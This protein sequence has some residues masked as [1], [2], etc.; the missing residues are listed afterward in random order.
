MSH[1]SD[2]VEQE[3]RLAGVGG[4][5]AMTDD[6]DHSDGHSCG[7]GCGCDHSESSSEEYSY[8]DELDPVAGLALEC[9]LEACYNEW[10][11][12]SDKGAEEQKG[13]KTPVNK[14]TK[15]SKEWRYLSTCKV[16][17]SSLKFAPISG[18]LSYK[19]NILLL[20]NP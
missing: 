4:L 16:Q 14:K 20:S 1:R 6:H 8:L 13:R 17:K 15:L 10:M 9:K 2:R 11:S 5:P 12:Q 3:M 18:T 19:S 7:S